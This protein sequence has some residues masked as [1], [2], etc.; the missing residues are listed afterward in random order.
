MDW[1]RR[2]WPRF[3]LTGDRIDRGLDCRSGIGRGWMAGGYGAIGLPGAGMAECWIHAFT[4]M[5]EGEGMAGMRGDGRAQ[6]WSRVELPEEGLA[7]VG[8]SGR[9][10]PRGLDYQ[11]LD[12]PRGLD[13]Q[14]LDCT[15]L[16]WPGD[17]FPGWR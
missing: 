5:T 10:W 16:D 17:G 6:D 13:Y 4:G 3:G 1:R 9:D 7:A 2:D 11:G 15:G 14:G 8:L 12:W